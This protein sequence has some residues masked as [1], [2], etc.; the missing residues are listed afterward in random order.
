MIN[1]AEFLFVA[2]TLIDPM[3][4]GHA[5]DHQNSIES[6]CQ[7]N[8]ICPGIRFYQISAVHQWHFE[9]SN[10]RAIQNFFIVMVIPFIALIW[11]M[12]K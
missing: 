7:D 3:F 8:S 2:D 9:S 11:Y 10:H 6:V 4:P 5:G 1:G 12:Q